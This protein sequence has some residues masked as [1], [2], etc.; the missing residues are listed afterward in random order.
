M[1]SDFFL[2]CRWCQQW[3]GLQAGC[4]LTAFGCGECRD[5]QGGAGGAGGAGARRSSHSPGRGRW[6]HTAASPANT[7]SDLL[8]CWCLVYPQPLSVNNCDDFTLWSVED[9]HHDLKEIWWSA[10]GVCLHTL[11]ASPWCR[12]CWWRCR[13]SCPRPPCSPPSPAWAPGPCSP[14]P[15]PGT[16]WGSHQS[17]DARI[18]FKK[19]SAQGRMG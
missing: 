18:K 1:T 4:G 2:T 19:A 7:T 16:T 6:A 14:T 17:E 11:P 3:G 12:A 9:C 15:L 5:D 10:L 13:C 8:W